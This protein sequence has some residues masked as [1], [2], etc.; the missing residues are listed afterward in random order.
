M[1]TLGGITLSD[2]LALR[3]LDDRP[4]IAQNVLPTLM[5]GV[6]VQQLAIAGGQP[7]SLVADET[8]GSITYKQAEDVRGLQTSG[9]PVVLS[10]PRG[11]YTVMIEA[12]VWR[13]LVEWVDVQDDDEG[14]G[15]IDLI[16]KG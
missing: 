12:V 9:D 16:I 2:H 7:L 5:G 8:G 11:S 1:V 13:P 3:G 4:V 6:V 15:S 10:H 14:F